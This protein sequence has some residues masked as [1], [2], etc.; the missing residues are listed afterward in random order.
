MTPEMNV[1]IC[2]LL[3]L[4]ALFGLTSCST[5]QNRDG[6]PIVHKLHKI[7]IEASD[8]QSLPVTPTAQAVDL[9]RFQAPKALV[10][11]QLEGEISSQRGRT[12][13]YRNEDATG[14]LSLTLSGLPAGWGNMPPERAVAS[15][16]SEVRQR[17]INQALQDSANALTIVSENLFDLEGQPCAQAKMRWVE[18]GRPIQNQSLLVTLIDGVLIRI[19]NVS[20][21]Q[22]PRWLLTQSKRALAEFKA[23]QKDSSKPQA[24]SDN[25]D[26]G[27][28][29][30]KRPAR[31]PGLAEV[32]P[33][34]NTMGRANNPGAAPVLQHGQAVVRVA[35]CSL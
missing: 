8:E 15:Y 26:K 9:S 18:Q 5:Q 4:I 34:L 24:S 32:F 3:L 22:N 28:A 20:Y 35:A 13:H 6:L 12:L 29:E 31:D 14:Y 1:K 2:Y 10:G 25:A 7:S 30:Q 23:A 11:L 21:L 19:N 17:R 33:A 16:Y 27:H